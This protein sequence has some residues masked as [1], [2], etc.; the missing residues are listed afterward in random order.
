MHVMAMNDSSSVMCCHRVLLWSGRSL[1][2]IH[3]KEET[4]AHLKFV[5]KGKI[6]VANIDAVIATA[7]HVEHVD[8]DVR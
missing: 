6:C 1:H 4:K 2:W 7:F 5:S 8:D 3:R